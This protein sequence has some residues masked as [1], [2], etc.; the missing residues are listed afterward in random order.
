MTRRVYLCLPILLGLAWTTDKA[1]AQEDLKEPRPGEKLLCDWVKLLKSAD[2]EERA[3]AVHALGEM[4]GFARVAVPSLIAA[5][6]DTDAGVRCQT[7]TAL[8]NMGFAATPALPALAAALQDKERS[9]RAAAADALRRL[10]PR[11]NLVVAAMLQALKDPDEQVGESVALFCWHG[12]YRGAVVG[13]PAMIDGLADS[14]AHVRKWAAFGLSRIGPEA[15]A[16]V[17]ALIKALRDESEEVR[18]DAAGALAYIGPQAREAVPALLAVFFEDKVPGVRSDAA[19]ALVHLH[20][21]DTWSETSHR[22]WIRGE[23]VHLTVFRALQ[24]GNHR[25]LST[26]ALCLYA[27]P[28]PEPGKVLPT[29]TAA[30]KDSDPWARVGAALVLG[31]M[32]PQAQLGRAGVARGTWRPGRGCPNLP[33]RG[34]VAD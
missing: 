34:A 26:I 15:R 19:R 13:I 27:K 17:P 5:L 29:L 6:R 22:A 24:T 1:V 12:L 31:Q 10:G 18:K 32:G 4:R 33:G 11:S 28:R 16:A 23:N 20:L 3:K 2:A 14:E 7:A 30:L 9:V 21:D 8:G 25:L